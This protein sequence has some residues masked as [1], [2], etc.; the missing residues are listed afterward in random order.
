[1]PPKHTWSDVESGTNGRGWTYSY[2]TD[3]D[4]TVGM[5]VFDDS[6]A[7]ITTIPNANH[8]SNDSGESGVG[9]RQVKRVM[10]YDAYLRH[11]NGKTG[12]ALLILTFMAA[13]MISEV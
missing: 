4:G 7:H 3:A 9:T 1:M 11:Q 8:P 12:E 10:A 6:G 5:D 13:E 2:T